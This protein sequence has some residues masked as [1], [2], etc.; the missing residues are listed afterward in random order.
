MPVCGVASVAIGPQRKG[1]IV[2]DASSGLANAGAQCV[3]GVDATE[4]AM[5]SMRA[6][7]AEKGTSHEATRPVRSGHRRRTFSYV[8]RR[9]GSALQLASA[10][11]VLPAATTATSASG[12]VPQLTATATTAADL[13]V[14]T[15]TT[16]GLWQWFDTGA[17]GFGAVHVKAECEQR[18]ACDDQD[19]ID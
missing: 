18:E 14:D 5:N 1:T 10:A 15:A 8:W 6:W 19:S 3:R 12:A 7:T 16:A 13:L 9:C 2:S 17:I 4:H 11:A